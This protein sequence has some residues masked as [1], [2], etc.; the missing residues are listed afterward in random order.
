LNDAVHDIVQS[1]F[2]YSDENVLVQKRFAIS[3][4]LRYTG[5]VQD[6]LKL[7]HQRLN[8]TNRSGS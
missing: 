7:L 2:I 4:A 8:A 3:E 6:N 1:S 5:K